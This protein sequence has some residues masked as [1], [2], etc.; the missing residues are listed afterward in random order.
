MKLQTKLKMKTKIWAKVLRTK[1]SPNG[2]YTLHYT[3]YAHY[4][5]V[6]A[7]LYGH[8]HGNW[9]GILMRHTCSS[10]Q[11][12][13]ANYRP[14][15]G[16]CRLRVSIID[17]QTVSMRPTQKKHTPK[18]MPPWNQRC[19]FNLFSKVH[20]SSKI[21]RSSYHNRNAYNLCDP[22]SL[23]APQWIPTHLRTSEWRSSCFSALA[24]CK[25]IGNTLQQ[26]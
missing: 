26:S 10:C 1:M 23:P 20:K 12:P 22:I 2:L 9:F 17:M 15:Q 11:L 4:S 24:I 19:Y 3:M 7:I 5:S 8:I 21:Q 16:N 18:K 13:V 6:W 14:T 25:L